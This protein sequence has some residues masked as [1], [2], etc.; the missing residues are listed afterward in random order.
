MSGPYL[1]RGEFIIL[2]TDRVSINSLQYEMVLTTRHLILVDIR[3]AQFLPQKIPLSTVVSVNGGKIATGEPVITLSFSDTSSTGDPGQ[4]ALIFSQ[5]PGEQRKRER[6][7]WLKKLMGLIVSVRQE[8]INTSLPT[9]DKEHGIQPSIRRPVAPERMSPY[10]TAVDTRPVP[11]ELTILPDEPESLDVPE[12]EQK[13]P[14]TAFL[15]EDTKPGVVL[16]TPECDEIPLA[17]GEVTGS[18]DTT[19]LPEVRE[20]VD[21]QPVPE[22]EAEFPDPAPAGISA[23]KQVAAEPEADSLAEK[24]FS[25]SL[26]E[27]VKSLIFPKEKRESPDTGTTS[28]PGI[29]ETEP[30]QQ[31][32][33]GSPDMPTPSEEKKINESTTIPEENTGLPDTAPAGISAVIQ[34]TAEPAADSSAEKSF[35]LTINEAMKSLISSKEKRELPDTGTPS[36]FRPEETEPPQQEERGSQEI[37]PPPEKRETIESTTVPE[38]NTELSDT[39]TSSLPGLEETDTAQ[40][41]EPGTPHMPTPHEPVVVEP[42]TVS[43]EAG[44]IT[45]PGQ[46]PAA[47]STPQI[48]KSPLP[49]DGTGSQRQ[50]LIAVTAIILVILGIVG[51]AVFYP[52]YFATPGKEPV[53]LPTPTLKQTPVQQTS[54]SQTPVQQTPVPTQVVI[55]PDGVWVRVIYEG[56]YHGW[57]GNP[58]SLRGVTGSGDQIYKIRDSDGNVQVQ[59][60]KNDYSGNTLTVEIYRNGDLINRRTRSTPMGSIDLLIDAKTG[61]P[62]GITPV[63]TNETNQTGSGS[64]RVMYF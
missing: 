42:P 17:S 10:T 48:P 2:T 1:K 62:P 29:E 60:S 57:V 53:P 26:W 47:E 3:N 5:Q 4:M 20:I 18:P 21:S 49:S 14:G 61:N 15:E 34:V 64:G 8:T 56:I 54:V 59:I 13:F 58:G 40:Q 44:N 28:P 19:P 52:Q 11:V 30:A 22:D 23:V 38:E 27:A 63:V 32:E 25:H 33:Q 9:T 31:E 41:E 43:P 55:P 50:T 6:D 24:S 51:G 7:E 36:L 37:I 39:G 12:E 35:A 46:Q 45:E 16:K